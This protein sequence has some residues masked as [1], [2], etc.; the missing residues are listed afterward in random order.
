MIL[1]YP[2]LLIE[3]GASSFVFL[4]PT[5]G[6]SPIL[7]LFEHLAHDVLGFLG[8]E[9]GASGIITV[10]CRVRDR[11]THIIQ[12][13]AIHQVYDQFQL[14]KALEISYLWLVTG[15]NQGLEPG[16][17]QGRDSPAQDGLFAK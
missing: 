1:I 2:P 6:V 15:F 16:F 8:D 12:A 4:D 10:L 9:L 3:P 13:S 11:I 5:R 7:D 17:N 14:V